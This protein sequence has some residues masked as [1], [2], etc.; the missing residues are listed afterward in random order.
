[1]GATVVGDERRPSEMGS[2]ARRFRSGLAGNGVGRRREHDV[3][4][5]EKE[6]RRGGLGGETQGLIDHTDQGSIQPQDEH[7]T[8]RIEREM[9]DVAF[10]VLTMEHRKSRRPSC[11]FRAVTGN[12]RYR[13]L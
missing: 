11:R 3:T 2:R 9:M 7:S 12:L 1:M 13:V 10:A 6:R 8:M 5:G 4:R